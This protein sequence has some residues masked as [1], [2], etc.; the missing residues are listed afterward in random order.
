MV[1]YY[2]S[3]HYYPPPSTQCA[4]NWRT[5]NHALL[6]PLTLRGAGEQPYPLFLF[7]VTQS[8]TG[9]NEESLLIVLGGDFLLLLRHLQQDAFLN[10][11]SAHLASWTHAEQICNVC[12]IFFCKGSYYDMTFVYETKT[13]KTPNLMGLFLCF[14]AK[15]SSRELRD[16]NVR[17]CKGSDQHAAKIN[18]TFVWLERRT[19]VP[20][21]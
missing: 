7:V 17:Q 8:L 18:A 14:P 10:D 12:Q 9:Q 3:W 5:A 16:R 6:K 15:Y 20:S 4:L 13:L 2:G 19:A 21:W 1:I 11:L